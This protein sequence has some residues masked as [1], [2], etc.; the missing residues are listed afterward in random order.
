MFKVEPIS[1]SDGSSSYRILLTRGD[2]AKFSVSINNIFS[3]SEY[4]MKDTDILRMTVRR[5]ENDPEILVQKEVVG[6][7]NIYIRPEDTEEMFFGDYMYDVELTIDDDV[8]TIIT[9]SPFKLL[10]EITY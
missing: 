3:G 2:S 1:Q 4:E 9:P 8:F 7:N 6:S 5:N 10:T